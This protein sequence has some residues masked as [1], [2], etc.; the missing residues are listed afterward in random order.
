MPAA[1]RGRLWSVSRWLFATDPAACAVRFSP[2]PRLRKDIQTPD[3]KVPAGGF[4]G[5]AI[6]LVGRA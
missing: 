4:G 2:L 5:M 3:S 1:V 6:G